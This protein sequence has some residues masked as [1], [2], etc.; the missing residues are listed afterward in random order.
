MNLLR[1]VKSRKTLATT[2]EASFKIYVTQYLKPKIK[3]VRHRGYL[4]FFVN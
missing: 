1:G 3:K 4:V 2:R